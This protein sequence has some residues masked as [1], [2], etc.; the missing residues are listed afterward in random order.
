MLR[1]LIAGMRSLLY[2][3]ERNTQIEEE[4]RGFFQASV[5]DKIRSGMSPERAQRAARIEIGSGD[6]VRHKVWS[7]SW[8]SGVDSLVRELRLTFR[9]LRKSPGFTLTAV[10]TL[11]FAIGATSAIFSIVNGVLL[12][13]LHFPDADR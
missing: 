1:S 9:Q 8:E 7:A 11:A 10:L 4:L 2:P 12:Q 5:E 6:M 3:V 13:P